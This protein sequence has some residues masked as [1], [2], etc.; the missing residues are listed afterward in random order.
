MRFCQKSGL[1]QGRT[2][3]T[4]EFETVQEV[5]STVRII[6]SLDDKSKVYSRQKRMLSILAQEEEVLVVLL[7]PRADASG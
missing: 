2:V 1:L 5:F 6:E 7:D 3:S 4:P